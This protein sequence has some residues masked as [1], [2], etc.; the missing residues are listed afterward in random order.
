M[1]FAA[2]LKIGTHMSTAAKKERVLSI[3]VAIGMYESRNTH[4]GNLS[5]GQRKRLAIALELVNNPPVLVLDEPTSYVDNPIWK[6]KQIEIHLFLS[7]TLRGLDSSTCN[8][9]ITLLKKLAGEGRNVIFTIHQPSALTFSM[10]DHLYAIA[11]GQ[12][13][14]AGGPQNLVPFLS[15]ANLHC[16]ESY[17]PVDYCKFESGMA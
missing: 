10:F 4:T 9:L 16:P 12:C 5:G 7:V 6:N 15:A 8:Q 2:N 17:N 13:I 14:Y 1:H 3:L 11:E